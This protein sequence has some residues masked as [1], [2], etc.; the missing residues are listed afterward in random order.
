M[1]GTGETQDRCLQNTVYAKVFL[2]ERRVVVFDGGVDLHAA[3]NTMSHLGFVDS[4]ERRTV[5]QANPPRRSISDRNVTDHRSRPNSPESAWRAGAN[6]STS[7]YEL[8]R[9]RMRRRAEHQKTTSKSRNIRRL[10]GIE[11]AVWRKGD[12]WF[13]MLTNSNGEGGVIGACANEAQAMRDA[14][15]SLEEKLSALSVRIS[16]NLKRS[17]G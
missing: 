8:V 4:L 5:A 14:H 16:R 6:R 2:R 1:P 10:W 7:Q 3:E 12:V 9:E 13:W 17:N 11:V 15:L